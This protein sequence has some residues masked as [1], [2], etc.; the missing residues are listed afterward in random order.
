[1]SIAIDAEERIFTLH[2]EN[3]TY[4][5]KADSFGTL[6]H[7]YYGERTDDSDKSYAIYMSGRGFSGNPYDMGKEHK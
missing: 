4:Q 7:V 3:T 5:M 1:M 2:T 6:L